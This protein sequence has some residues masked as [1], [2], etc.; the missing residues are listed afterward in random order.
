[1]FVGTQHT[2]EQKKLN[3]R[4]VKGQ[5]ATK[6][7]SAPAESCIKCLWSVMPILMTARTWMVK[8]IPNR[9]T[10]KD[11]TEEIGEARVVRQYNSYH[12]LMRMLC[13]CLALMNLLLSVAPPSSLVTMVVPI[14]HWDVTSDYLSNDGQRSVAAGPKWNH[15][16]LYGSFA[17]L[18][19]VFMEKNEN[20]KGESEPLPEWPSPC[21]NL[22]QRFGYHESDRWPL[23]DG[24]LREEYYFEAL[25]F[26]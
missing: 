11:F 10:I 2:K 5:D 6:I 19:F 26:P 25:A 16:K 22:R 17:T 12:L 20:E 13:L 23:D 4:E 8:K 14:L 21:C 7:T 18:W 1:M 15:V 3:T 9:T 24:R